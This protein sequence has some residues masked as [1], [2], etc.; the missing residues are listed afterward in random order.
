MLYEV[1]L[2]SGLKLQKSI[3]L[4]AEHSWAKSTA[5]FQSYIEDTVYTTEKDIKQ[6]D[7]CLAIASGFSENERDEELLGGYDLV[8]VHLSDF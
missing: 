2:K 7:V 5:V 8:I 4:G 3:E 6:L 1:N